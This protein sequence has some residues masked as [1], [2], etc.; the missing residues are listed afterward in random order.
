[1]KALSIKQ[2]W[3]WAIVNGFKPVENRTWITKFRG[4]FLVHASQQLDKRGIQFIRNHIGIDVPATFATG[5]IVGSVDLVDVVEPMSS[6]WFFG[7]LGFVLQ[8]PAKCTFV[9]MK[10]HL[11]L[12]ESKHFEILTLTRTSYATTVKPQTKE[13]P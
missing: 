3:A 1:M 10:G 8:R 2:P 4:R 5:G 13:F 12:W 11:G 9:P 6:P 7:A